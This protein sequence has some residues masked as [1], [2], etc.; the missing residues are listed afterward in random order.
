MATRTPCY[1]D[2]NGDIRQMT[3]SQIT[4]IVNQAAALY[5]Q[6]PSVVLT[7]ETTNGTTGFLAN[8]SDTRYTS[9][10]AKVVTGYTYPSEASTQEPQLKTIDWRRIKQTKSTL[11]EPTD[12]DSVRYPLFYIDDGGSN[13]SVQ[14]MDED[15]FYDTFISPAIDRVADTSYSKYKIHTSTTLTDYTSLGSIFVDTQANTAGMTAGEIG[16][17]GTR[18]ED[19]TT[20]ATYYLMERTSS[21]GGPASYT[22]PALITSTGSIDQ[23]TTAEFDSILEA[24]MR[25]TAVT[26][27]Y[28]ELTYSIATSGTSLGTNIVNK[29][30][31]T[32]GTGT[33]RTR[34]VNTNDYRAQEM[35][36]G[37][38]G[39]IN[40]WKLAVRKA[41]IIVP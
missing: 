28:G 36:N 10:D 34:F 22:P 8:M 26:R 39:T 41:E 27:I 38:V 32:G 31:E 30:M 35:P 1:V 11:S 21:F 40:T 33:Y 25:W 17:A 6:N 13:F 5:L 19:A 23:Y 29:A 9:G 24:N 18:Q 16:T 7:R 20:N 3:D 14:A 37:T 4:E 2:S 12:T 15:D